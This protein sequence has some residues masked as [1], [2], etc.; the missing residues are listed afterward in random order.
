M[1]ETKKKISFTK[2]QAS[3]ND[4]IYFNNFDGQIESP[5]SLTINFIDRNYGIGADGVVLLEK[6][7]IADAKMRIF[8]TDGTLSLMAANSIRCAAKYLY[9][10]G[11]VNKKEMQI[12]TASGVIDVK[13]YSYNGEIRS[14]QVN[15]GAPD[16]DPAHIPVKTDKEKIIN[17]PITVDGVEHKINCVTICNSHCVIFGDR[18]E[19]VDM[20]ALGDS[21][22]NSGILPEYINT[23]LARVVNKNT[24]KM[25]CYE[26]AV[27][28]ESLGCGT[29]ACA[30]VVAAI[31][32]GLCNL[33]EDITVKMRGG[34][35]TIRYDG[36][37]ISLLGDANK[38]YDGVVEY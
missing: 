6:S 1:R 32:N 23:E 33:N 13:L 24:I 18:I 31:E 37:T 21:M 20:N 5:E 26:R 17:C 19:D 3:G 27:N 10:K 8:N 7:D 12:E 36:K 29:G 22:R 14:A 16:F 34:D 28:G 35:V 9:D 15:L 4:D 25:R 30:T 2:M 11:L 38:V